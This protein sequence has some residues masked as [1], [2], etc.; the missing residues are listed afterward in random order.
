MV[1][2]D[3]LRTQAL[4]PE[5]GETTAPTLTLD[6]LYLCVLKAAAAYEV[7]DHVGLELVAAELGERN[8]HGV[9]SCVSCL[10]VGI[11]IVVSLLAI[12]ARRNERRKQLSHLTQPLDVEAEELAQAAEARLAVCLDQIP[13]L[14]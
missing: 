1:G 2:A 11:A 7:L 12:L 3:E 13:R 6:T 5:L 4:A 14:E 9:S 8:Q 10:C